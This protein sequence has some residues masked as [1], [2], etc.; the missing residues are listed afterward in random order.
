M[1]KIKLLWQQP[2]LYFEE[3]LPKKVNWWRT[4]SL[5]SLNGIMFMHYTMKSGGYYDIST[6]KSFVVSILTLITLGVFYG[7]ISNLI[8][9]LLISLTGHLF[10]AQNELKKIYNALTWTYLPLVI[11]IPLLFSNLIMAKILLGEVNTVTSI[12]LSILVILSTLIQAVIGVWQIILLYKGLKVAQSLNAT[13]TILNYI[14]GFAIFGILNFYL[15]KP[16]L[17]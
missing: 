16:Y 8:V 4:L 9:G 14:L 1:K 17:G 7:I 10:N 13:K 11:S 5:F 12:T 2:K 3:S 6:T 15:I